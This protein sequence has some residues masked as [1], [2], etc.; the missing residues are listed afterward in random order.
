M[1]LVDCKQ[2]IHP[3][4]HLQDFENRMEQG[5]Q[6]RETEENKRGGGG[7]D[8]TVRTTTNSCWMALCTISPALPL[9]NARAL[10]T[11]IRWP[12]TPPRGDLRAA[13]TN[14]DSVQQLQSCAGASGELQVGCAPPTF[15][16]CYLHGAS[17]LTTSGKEGLYALWRFTALSITDV[18]SWSSIS[19]WSG[20]Q[21]PR[22]AVRGV[23]EER[24]PQH[25]NL[26][27]R[28]HELPLTLRGSRPWP[29][30]M[31]STPVPCLPSSGKW[32]EF[33]GWAPGQ[34]NC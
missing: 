12:A 19:C 1:L 30:C 14:G 21:G 29:P 16:N 18:W 31:W 22:A 10:Q 15:V 20:E 3:D 33:T 27:T 34:I 25:H 5:A 7:D 8:R 24:N 23:G 26:G 9:L 13:L 28:D 11:A 17:S 32:H 6:L 2:N 4:K